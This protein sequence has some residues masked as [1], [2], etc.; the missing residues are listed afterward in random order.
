MEYQKLLLGEEPYFIAYVKASYPQHCHS[1]IEL[2]YCVHGRVRVTVDE[3]EYALN[4]NDILCIDSLSRHQLDIEGDSGIL[5]IEFGSQFVGSYFQEFARKRFLLPHIIGDEHGEYAKALIPLMKKI[6][7]EYSNPDVAS[8]WAVRGYLNELFTQLVRIVPTEMQKNDTRQKQLERYLRIHKVFDY[9]KAHY[10][11]PISL[12]EAASL[13]GYD[14]NAFCKIFREITNTSFH[15]YLNLHRTSIAMR[16]LA[17]ENMSIG[18][19]GSQVGLP[20]AKTFGRIFKSHTGMSP[21]EYRQ[22]IFK[23]MITSE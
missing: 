17:S 2:V 4:E 1:E 8:V 23:D 14:P 12:S 20:V 18:E 11:E 6:Y 22:S 19:I 3:V 10:S 9:V 5:D 21:K 13:V 16:L 15:Q 7:D